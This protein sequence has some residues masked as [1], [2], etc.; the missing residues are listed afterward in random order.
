[1]PK[2][3][4]QF[5]I[6]ARRAIRDF[7]A[8]DPLMSIRTLTESV[9]KKL[10][11]SFDREYITRL[12]RKVNRETMPDLDRQKIEPRLQQLRETFRIAREALL[13]IAFGKLVKPAEKTGAWR[14]I[15][16]NDKLLLEMEIELGIYTRVL[17][18]HIVSPDGFRDRPVPEENLAAIEK[19]FSMWGLPKMD[20]A[21]RI[22]V[23]Q[24]STSMPQKPPEQ[25]QPELIKKTNAGPV[26]LDP[27]LQLH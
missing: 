19:T 2:V 15:A 8:L 13:Q 1:M 22:E 6:E 7:V 23:G 24:A 16:L 17:N 10:N 4:H 27:E 3:T 25:P 20:L 11:H 12:Y 26:P 18:P 21:R 14:Q 5:E 9:S